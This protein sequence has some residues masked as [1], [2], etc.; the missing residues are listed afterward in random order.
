M[1]RNVPKNIY[2]NYLSMAIGFGS[3][4]RIINVRISSW[5]SHFLFSF[6][7]V[8][9]LCCFVLF[10]FFSFLFLF[11]SIFF[12]KYKLDFI[13]TNLFFYIKSL[14][15]SLDKKNFLNL[16]FISPYLK[17]IPWYILKKSPVSIFALDHP[18]ARTGSLDQMFYTY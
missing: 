1:Y 7:F 16:H 6:V 8:S 13:I 17:K 12:H 18:K 15:I 3:N 10:M 11:F 14:C 5:F 9:L 4:Q 2:E